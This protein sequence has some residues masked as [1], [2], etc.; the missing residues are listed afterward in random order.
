MVF[1]RKVPRFFGIFALIFFLTFSWKW[2]FIFSNCQKSMQNFSLPWSSLGKGC[3]QRERGMVIWRRS[4]RWRSS[5]MKKLL[6]VASL[7]TLL[8]GRVKT[9]FS[10]SKLPLQLRCWEKSWSKPPPTTSWGSTY[11]V[12]Q[13][14]A[15]ASQQCGVRPHRGGEDRV[16]ALPT[17]NWVVKSISK[18]PTIQSWMHYHAK[19]ERAFVISLPP[20]PPPASSAERCWLPTTSRLTCPSTLSMVLGLLR[21]TPGSAEVVVELPSFVLVV[22]G[23]FEILQFFIWS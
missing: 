23:F 1:S 20:L 6:I 8:I 15:K 13:E 10:P 11:L 18:D 5:G 21:S 16:L 17:W 9:F 3:L 22:P 14:L 4:G 2:K 12:S 7:Q 19:W